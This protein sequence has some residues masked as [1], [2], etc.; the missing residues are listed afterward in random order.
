MMKRRWGRRSR[1]MIAADEAKIIS[2]LD[3][4]LK[5]AVLKA[6]PSVSDMMRYPHRTVATR[7]PIS[8]NQ[9]FM[10]SG[11]IIEPED[12]ENSNFLYTVLAKASL[13][14][15]SNGVQPADIKVQVYPVDGKLYSGEVLACDFH[16][17]LA[18]I[19]FQSDTPLQAVKLR[20]LDDIIPL[21]PTKLHLPNDPQSFQLRP[22]S[23]LLKIQPGD[24]VVTLGRSSSGSVWHTSGHF[25]AAYPEHD[26]KE[27]Y[28]LDTNE[29][30]FPRPWLGMKL[31]NLHTANLEILEQFLLKFPT[32]YSGV[33]V[34]KVFRLSGFSVLDNSAAHCCG[35][36]SEDV[37]VQ[38]DAALVRSTLEFFEKIW[39]KVG[40]SV[41][42]TVLRLSSGDCMK[43]TMK[44][45]EV[46][47]D[48]FYSLVAPVPLC[49]PKPVFGSNMFEGSDSEGSD[50]E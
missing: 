5:S 1:T 25:S 30:K 39:D 22:H 50:S 6:S 40:A 17:N 15:R 37:I 45:D 31:A 16:F 13:F 35:L 27:L 12:V 19:R 38:C 20:D 46:V 4:Q 8:H 7:G 24:T 34:T 11:T 28:S 48:N 10:G 23:I 42:L 21:D 43:L 33:I 41:E 44:V 32:F 14:T 9:V 3:I 2:N 26:C 18:A 36:H 47:R 29:K 49:W